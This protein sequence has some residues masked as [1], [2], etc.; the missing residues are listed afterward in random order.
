[1]REFRVFVRESVFP[2]TRAE[3]GD[4]LAPL[5]IAGEVDTYTKLDAISR[6]NSVG[7]WAL[8]IPAN[9]PQSNLFQPGRGIVIRQPGQDEPLFSGPITRIKKVWDQENPGKG[10][11]QVSGLDDN[12]LLAERLAWPNPAA[13]IHLASAYRYWQTNRSWPNVG[14]LLRRMFL[15]NFQGNASRKL[16]HVYIPDEASTANLFPDESA[17]VAR[18][19][20][21]QPDQLVELLS[22]AYSFR[23]RFVW[24]PSPS[25][26]ASNGNSA[27]SGPGILLKLEPIDVL[28]E[29]VR[30]GADLGNLRGYEYEFVAPKA[31]RLVVAT[32]PRTWKELVQT[33]TYTTGGAV[34]GYTENWVEKVGH[35]R[36]H[37]YY[38][39]DLYDP[40]WW[41]N[42]SL[43]PA[44]KQH[45]LAWSAAGFSATE[46]E[47]G[48]T[49]ERFRDRRDI[50]WQ[51]ITDASKGVGYA[52]DPP[53]WSKQQREILDEVAAFSLDQ[54]PQASI[55]IDPIEADDEGHFYGRD[56]RLGDVVR[57]YVDDGQARD[58]LVREVHLTASQEDGARV[59]PTVGT[60][61]T[62]E[63]PYLYAAVRSLW[64]RVA[65]IESRESLA[66]QGTIPT[67]D[68]AIKKAA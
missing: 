65:A 26:V 36:W 52:I 29:E 7:T 15:A 27:A 1:M 28:T 40:E 48:F 68:F 20:F 30:F 24:H 6:H 11:I 19:R 3:G 34:S 35:E 63:T 23:I 44:D 64:D 53:V 42:A 38:N 12:F 55:S 17:A 59:T 67:A 60:Y 31:T 49:G 14:E 33:P 9:E 8:Q 32:Q 41:G 54:G 10:L 21:D 50:A 39:N 13:D 51:W 25:A 46:T 37:G 18:L 2:R 56:Y 57:V 4:G 45:T 62:S 43:T 22:A 58:E 5:S 47:W 16:A 61:G 66:E